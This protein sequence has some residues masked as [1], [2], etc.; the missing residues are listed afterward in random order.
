M[1][2]ANVTQGQPGAA[3]AWVWS[4]ATRSRA[5]TTP[6]AK[7]APTSRRSRPGTARHASPRGSLSGRL[8]GLGSDVHGLPAPLAA[9]A[10]FKRPQLGVHYGQLTRSQAGGDVVELERIVSQV[11]ELALA[12]GIL[13]IQEG[14]GAHRLVGRGAATG[15]L[16]IVGVADLQRRALVLDQD[17]V[18]PAPWRLALEQRFQAV[19]IPAERGL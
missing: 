18:A 9:V 16:L 6:P 2:S 19:P 1:F 17:R 13:D 14:A 10:A 4:S 7:I 5:P 3:P 8:G 11:V 12:V 15:R